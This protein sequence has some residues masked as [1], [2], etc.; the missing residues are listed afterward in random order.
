MVRRS[1]SRLASGNFPLAGVLPS[2]I[3]AFPDLSPNIDLPADPH[4]SFLY[5]TQ[6]PSSK[7]LLSRKETTSRA[8]STSSRGRCLRY[9]TRSRRRGSSSSGSSLERS[10]SS[11]PRDGRTRTLSCRYVAALGSIRGRGTDLSSAPCQIRDPIQTEFV[12][13]VLFPSP[14]PYGR[15]TPR[16]ARSLQYDLD[17]SLWLPY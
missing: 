12:L 6:W 3:A 1:L 10:G 17:E 9:L 8:A 2:D 4:T 11:V 16:A 13:L 7:S 5:P 14:N 15:L